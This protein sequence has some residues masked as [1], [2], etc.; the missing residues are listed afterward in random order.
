MEKKNVNKCAHAQHKHTHTRSLSLSSTFRFHDSRPLFS[1]GVTSL[2]RIRVKGGTNWTAGPREKGVVPI[3]GGQ[4]CVCMCVF[5]CVCAL[6]MDHRSP[7]K[8]PDPCPP[9][10]LTGRVFKSEQQLII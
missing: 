9:H 4:E 3:H 1:C 8:V 7:V 2:Q 5:V 10:I 6:K